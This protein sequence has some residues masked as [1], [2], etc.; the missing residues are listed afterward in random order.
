MIERHI[1]PTWLP[2]C[3]KFDRV[4][5]LLEGQ[6]WPCGARADV[7]LVY[8]VTMNNLS[9]TQ[10][11]GFSV[12][13]T[14]IL[15]CQLKTTRVRVSTWVRENVWW[16]TLFIKSEKTKILGC[17]LKNQ[18]WVIDL[19]NVVVI[20]WTRAANHLFP[21]SEETV[22]TNRAKLKNLPVRSCARPLT[23]FQEDPT[24]E[25][26]ARG[27]NVTMRRARRRH[28]SILIL[29]PWIRYRYCTVLTYKIEFTVYYRGVHTYTS[30]CI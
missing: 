25:F 17:Q 6:T 26:F 15:G 28:V 23:K 18:K 2:L 14:K 24:I 22:C 16:T 7:M 3:R 30:H 9:Q 10:W 19:G 27:A 20:D 8:S 21:S 12:K 1:I 11:L 13:K 5:L 4:V 29:L